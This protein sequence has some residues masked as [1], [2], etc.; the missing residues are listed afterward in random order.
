MWTFRAIRNIQTTNR[1]RP[2]YPA[3]YFRIRMK[4]SW[5]RSSLALAV[6]RQAEEE[7]V[8]H[9]LV[10][11]EEEGQLLD[12]SVPD[13]FHEFVVARCHGFSVAHGIRPPPAQKVALLLPIFPTGSASTRTSL[14]PR[15]HPLAR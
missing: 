15:D 3:R 2:W 5:T 14:S 9:D 12:P 13:G 8:E 6:P 11:L 4:T 10:P 7:V 1:S